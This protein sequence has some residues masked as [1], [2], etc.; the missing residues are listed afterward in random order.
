[1]YKILNWNVEK[2]R[3]WSKKTRLAQQKILDYDADIVILTESSKWINLNTNYPFR[4]HSTPFDR[5][6]DEYWVSIWS[7]WKIKTPIKTFAPRRTACGIVETPFG[8]IIIYGTI[9]PYHMAGV[10]GQQYGKVSYKAWEFHEKDLYKQAKDWNNIQ[11]NHPNLPFFVIGDFN[12]TRYEN[13]GYGTKK[14][15]KILTKQLEKLNLDCITAI[16]LSDYLLPDPKTGRTRRNI[17][18]ICVSTSFVQK[19]QYYKIG[20]WNHFD[21]NNNRMSDHN[22]IF[23]E[24][25]Y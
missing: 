14:V 8:E 19:I 6:P 7:K 24:F 9:I 22:A 25:E 3:K 2:P 4:L 15:R 1:M 10:K 11:N 18:H 5:V 23:M 21:E 20:A 13:K 16:D 17:D 12:Q